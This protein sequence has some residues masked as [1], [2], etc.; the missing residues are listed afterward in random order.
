MSKWSF[1]GGNLRK[2]IAAPNLFSTSSPSFLFF[3][4]GENPYQLTI[5]G[6][7]Y[8]IATILFLQ[9]S[10][11]QLL[12]LQLLLVVD[13]NTFSSCCHCCSWRFC[14]LLLVWSDQL[15]RTGIGPVAAPFSVQQASVSG[16][17][18]VLVMCCL[19]LFWW[20]SLVLVNDC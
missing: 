12:P 10:R 3:L 17:E 14:L 6:F 9:V 13:I 16:V 8:I 15:V 1:N 7:T 2:K 4:C 20:Y 18:W 5:I 19:I 11:C